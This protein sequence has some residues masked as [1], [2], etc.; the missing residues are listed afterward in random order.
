MNCFLEV[1]LSSRI[2]KGNVGSQK[3]MWEKSCISEKVKTDPLIH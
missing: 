1:D 3:H 2:G